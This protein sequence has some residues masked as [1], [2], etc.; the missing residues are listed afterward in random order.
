MVG[1][2]S[3]RAEDA[4]IF[5]HYS[6]PD[7]SRSVEMASPKICFESDRSFQGNIVEWRTH[8]T[9]QIRRG[10]LSRRCPYQLRAEIFA[11]PN[12]G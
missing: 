12:Q 10:L 6:A 4:A 1:R 9:A 7:L 8:G 11:P 2:K 5:R 3:R